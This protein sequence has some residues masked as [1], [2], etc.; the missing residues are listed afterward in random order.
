VNKQSFTTTTKVIEKKATT[1][2]KGT[3][4]LT[5]K[6]GQ[7]YIKFKAPAT[8]K[9]T[10]TF[11]NT[12]SS[13]KGS[14]FVE[15]QKKD[16]SSPKYSFL[17]DVKTKGGKANTLWLGVNGYKSSTGDLV[18]RCLPTRSAVV[19]LKKGQSLYFYFYNGSS[20]TTSTLKIK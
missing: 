1:V 5:I 8:K 3:T 19:K 18:G 11:S 2:K 12:K 17:Y 15:I 6:K 14:S 13:I 9:Y 4:K 10:F 16:A 7:G 20:K